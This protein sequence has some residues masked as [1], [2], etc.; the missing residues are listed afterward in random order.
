MNR[1][2]VTGA[3]GFVG[4]RLLPQLLSSGRAITV[5]TRDP[6]PSMH[7][8]GAVRFVSIPAIGSDTDW[9]EALSAC[10]MVIHLAAQVPGRGVDEKT[11]DEVN[12]R[13]TARLVEQAGASGVRS[14][15][16]MSSIF[17]L[18]DNAAKE[19]VNDFSSSVALSPYGLSKLAAEKH[20]AEFAGSGRRGVSL[21]PPLVY[22]STAKGNW[23]MLLKLAASPL[24]LPF[25]AVR[26]R[27][28]LVSVDNLADAICSAVNAGD[29]AASGNFA[30]SE[31]IAV[32]LE[33]IAS[34]LRA[35]MGRSGKLLPVPPKLLEI[36]LKAVG[37]TS[38]AT[39]LL[40]D[41]VVNSQRFQESYG[42]SPA[43][44]TPEGIR[45]AA[46]LFIDGGSRTRI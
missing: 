35:G 9:R 46:S 29:D 15:I 23:R 6:A 32:S 40:G 18:V 30:V 2:L 8:D 33:Q 11:F 10:S 44:E 28:S 16:F 36:A 21:R 24:P 12:N 34:L 37:R 22:G 7:S 4:R 17:S 41:L 20:V 39:S 14:F 43:V 5:A 26:N 31:N 3:S 27:R 45:R 25:G 13:G 1:I 42:W 38:M 19:P